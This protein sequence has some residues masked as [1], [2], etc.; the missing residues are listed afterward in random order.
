MK[1]TCRLILLALIILIFGAGQAVNAQTAATAFT[2]TIIDAAICDDPPQS[3]SGNIT[4]L[5][6]ID[7]WEIKLAAD[8]KLIIDVDAE[9]LGRLDAYLVVLDKNENIVGMNN[10]QDDGNGNISLDPYLE[11][12]AP[13]DD[14]Y[15]IGISSA[16]TDVEDDR[17]TGP[18]TFLVQC[19]G[20]SSSAKF[21]WPVDV[22]DLIGA[23]NSDAG[24]LINIF[25]ENGESSTPFPLGIGPISDIEFDP[26]SESVFVAV[27]AVGAVDVG[28][29]IPGRIVAI[30]PDSGSVVESYSLETESVVSLEAVEDKLYVVRVDSFG[31][32]FTLS[33][34]TFD[35]DLKTAKLTDVVSLGLDVRALAYS[36]SEK[37]LYGASGADL[38]KINL[39]SSPVGIENLGSPGLGEIVALDFSNEDVLYGVAR[40]GL[41]FNVTD[42]SSGQAVTIGDPIVGVKSLTFV[43]GDAQDVEP[44]K[45][46]CSSTLTGTTTA[47]SETDVPKLARLKLKKNP[48]HRAIGLFKFQGKAGE[49][50][51][52]RLAPEE[53]EAVVAGDKSSLRGL[54]TSWRTCEGKG[55]VFLGIRDAIPNVDFRARKKD[56]MPFDMSA[57]L[58][59]DGYYYVMVIRP[60]LRFYQADYCLTLESDRPD[61]VAWESLDVVWPGDDSEEDTT[62]SAD[63][64]KLAEPLSFEADAVATGTDNEPD[65]GDTIDKLTTFSPEPTATNLTAGETPV[66]SSTEGDTEGGQTAGDTDVVTPAVETFENLVV[67]G[68]NEGG[69]TAG[70][71]DMVTPAVETFE[72]PV[73]DGDT[74]GGQTAGDTDVVTP[75]VETFENP[76]VDGDTEGGQTADDTDVVTPAVET[77]ENPVVDGGD[78]TETEEDVPL[79]TKG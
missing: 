76:V 2:G 28:D 39:A 1:P 8:Q 57:D 12:T 3:Y 44:I 29:Y 38:I 77:F 71:T 67:D 78:G 52:L 53:E 75:A 64:T 68:D 17:T 74:E 55:R 9:D 22:G 11:V 58:P 33:L 62:L 46:V 41:I 6:Q 10:D 36:Q 56:Q 45:T 42:L 15:Y 5:F 43:V 13:S 31:E 21:K 26:S 72:N 69:Q 37:V 51:T 32:N 20:Q 59:E 50:I 63:E 40:S 30:N 79:T 35:T 60:L 25:P 48:L 16:S 14:Y 23:T 7:Y 49:K 18:Y 4:Q 19:S 54:V 66:Q 73:V 27:E 34:V 70:D 24:S 61:S 47:G 65:S